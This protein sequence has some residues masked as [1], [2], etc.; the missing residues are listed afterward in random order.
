MYYLN[1]TLK[2]NVYKVLQIKIITLIN[3]TNDIV[4]PTQIRVSR[5]NN[6]TIIDKTNYSTH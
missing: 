6:T 2:Q 1:V 5:A 4:V 3:F